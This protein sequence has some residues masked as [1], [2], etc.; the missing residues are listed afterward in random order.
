MP[1]SSQDLSAPD[2]IDEAKPPRRRNIGNN[3]R[4]V[5]AYFHTLGNVDAIIGFRS[6]TLLL[7]L[8]LISQLLWT[9]FSRTLAMGGY[10]MDVSI[11]DIPFRCNFVYAF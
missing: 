5:K 8:V 2:T 4:V 6:S 11:K 10:D 1:N 9:S 7:L 3:D